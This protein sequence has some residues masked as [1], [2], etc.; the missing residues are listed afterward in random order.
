ILVILTEFAPEFQIKFIRLPVEELRKNLKLDQRNLLTKIVW[1]IVFGQLR[2]YGEG[3]LKAHNIKFA[4]RVYGLLQTGDMSEKY[5][6]GLI[7]QIEAELVEIYSHPDLINT[8]INHGGEVELAA[9]LSQ[10]VRELLT[11]KGFNL[12]NYASIQL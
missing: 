6:L 8:E 5:L 4:D 11:V 2:R 9:L 12:S 10:P 7:P 1:S 3:L